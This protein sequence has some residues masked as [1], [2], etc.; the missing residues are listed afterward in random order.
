VHQN[1]TIQPCRKFSIKTQQV[2][3]VASLCM[4]KREAW[5]RRNG[6]CTVSTKFFCKNVEGRGQ[7]SVTIQNSAFCKSLAEL[8]RGSH[9]YFHA[10]LPRNCFSAVL[11]P[12]FLLVPPVCKP[13]KQGYGHELRSTSRQSNTAKMDKKLY[14]NHFFDPASSH[15]TI[16][17]FQRKVGKIHPLITPN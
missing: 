14:Q 11:R 7:S 3:T 2:T 9:Y 1:G 12:I 16:R 5:G 17:D 6:G 15:Q 13:I 4:R 8:R 10:F